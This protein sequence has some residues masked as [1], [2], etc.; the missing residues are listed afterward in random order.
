MKVTRKLQQQVEVKIRHAIATGPLPFVERST[1]TQ[2][3][4]KPESGKTDKS[5]TQSLT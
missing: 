5:T 3:H 2:A 4:P 1:T